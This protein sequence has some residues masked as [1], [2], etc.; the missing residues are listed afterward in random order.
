MVTSTRSKSKSICQQQLKYLIIFIKPLVTNESL[1]KPLGAFQ[2]KI[3]KKFDKKLDKQNTK[4]IELQTKI[5]IQGNALQKFEIKSDDNEQYSRRSS[6]RIHGVQYDEN[7]DISVINKVERCCDEIAVK[8][9][10]NEIYSV[11]YIGKP[12][13]DTDSKQKVR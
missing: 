1:E 12:I 6:I 3:M 10:M 9:D 13:F 8:P 2:E 11:N 7:V 4:I 5:A